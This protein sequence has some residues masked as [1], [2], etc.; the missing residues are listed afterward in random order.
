MSV[1]WSMKKRLSTLRC[2][3]KHNTEDKCES[4]FLPFVPNLYTI[5]SS[6]IIYQTAHSEGL[7]VLLRVG[8]Y[9]CGERSGG[10]L[11]YWL[12]RDDADMK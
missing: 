10:G 4:V 9:I 12:Y 2:N 6:H 5:F 1:C 8:P 11:P 7:W 3:I